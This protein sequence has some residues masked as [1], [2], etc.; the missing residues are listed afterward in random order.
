MEA[1]NVAADMGL[2]VVDVDFVGRA[3]PERQVHCI[4]RLTGALLVAKHICAQKQNSLCQADLHF[5]PLR[6]DQ[7][8]A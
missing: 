8:K 4:V 6:A 7:G 1:L 2:P 3:F 5:M